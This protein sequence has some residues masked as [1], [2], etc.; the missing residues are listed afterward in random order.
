GSLLDGSV[1]AVELRCDG[2]APEA[3]GRIRRLAADGASGPEGWTF[4]FPDTTS[5][6]GGAAAVL[7]E[8]GRILS[9]SP[10]RETLEQSFVRL[11]AGGQA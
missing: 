1:R 7:A 2:L 4:T 8:G 9:L 3:F 6:N 10:Q 5:A 11:A